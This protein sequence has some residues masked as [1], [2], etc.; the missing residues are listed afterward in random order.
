M[1][2][3]AIP[4]VTIATREV[5]ALRADLEAAPFTLASA[6][7]VWG[8]A[9]GQALHRGNRIP[10]RRAVAASR[11]AAGLPA[12]AALAALFVLGDPVDAADVRAALPALGVDGAVR[13]GLV[14]V[15]GD[16]IRPAVDLRPYGFI[17]A[18][19]VGEWWIASDLGELATGGAL[20]EDHVLGVGGASATLSGLMISTPVASALD[21]GTG[22]GIQALHAS[23]HAD[24][25]VATDIS[26]RALAFAAL[27]AALNGVTT[28]ELR[29]GSLFEPV[30]GERFDHIVSN[31]PFVITPRV[32]G[33]PAYEYRDAG[34]VGDALVEGV[35]AD[36]ADHLTPGGIAQLLGNWE[37]RAGQPGLERVAAWLDAAAARTGSGLDAW[38]VEREVQDAAL[39]AE[40]WIRDGG[41]RAGT[42]ESEALV[43][44][45][46]DDFAARGVDA[47]GFGYLTLRRPV[48]GAPTLR[49]LERLPG[50]LG[51]NPTG[52]G[53]HLAASL[54]AH[55]AVAARDDDA[56]AGT[57]LVV[58]GDVTEERHHWPGA[59]DPSVMTLRQGAGFGREV[60]LDTGLAAL[61]GACDGELTVAAIVGAVAQLTGVD[62]TAL[63]AELIPRIRALVADG[64][65]LLPAAAPADPGRPAADA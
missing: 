39:Y 40:T 23:R 17:D 18:H 10:A 65:L 2:R 51:H 12:P 32:E 61:V 19:G 35:V 20:D 57:A 24:R 26:A 55:D 44:A 8:D 1:P 9:A 11:T 60:P 56:L 5:R 62:A 22:C 21:L 30:A 54:A 28:I 38:V 45:W 27:N 14:E 47:V 34:L 52:L 43:D 15:E 59:E 16:R 6:L 3:P 53:E 64:F 7:A 4:S 50:G 29:L 13:L 25:V 37:H 31:P 58:A 41:T 63:R 42:P 48:A 46:L 33:V 36:L 49:R